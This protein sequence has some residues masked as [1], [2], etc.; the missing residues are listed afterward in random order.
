[1]R[2]DPMYTQHKKKK[3]YQKWGVKG[4]SKLGL[5]CGVLKDDSSCH[6]LYTF[7]DRTK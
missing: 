7:N 5:M 4:Q 6:K 2:S 3:K 1:M